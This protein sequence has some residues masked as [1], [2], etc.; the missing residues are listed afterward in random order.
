MEILSTADNEEQ[1]G[2]DLSPMNMTS[3]FEDAG[4]RSPADLDS[5]DGDPQLPASFTLNK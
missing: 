5:Y 1:N 4:S 3:A 2:Q